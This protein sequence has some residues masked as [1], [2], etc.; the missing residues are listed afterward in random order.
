MHLKITILVKNHAE[1]CKVLCILY[2]SRFLFPVSNALTSGDIADTRVTA[3]LRAACLGTQLSNENQPVQTPHP[4]PVPLP[5]THIH[6][7]APCPSHPGLLPDRRGPSYTQ[8]PLKLFTLATLSLFTSV[9]CSLPW[10][11]RQRVWS[12]LSPRLLP[13]VWPPWHGLAR[14]WGMRV[15]L[16]P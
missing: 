11:P 5:G 16:L 15:K 14:F 1:N 12:T 4:Q 13:P 6:A 9:A 2:E 7:T 10:T 8:S 3:P